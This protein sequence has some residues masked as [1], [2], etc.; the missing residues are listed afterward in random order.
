LEHA[1]HRLTLGGRVRVRAE[2]AELAGRDPTQRAAYDAVI[3][4]G[5][6]PPAVAAECGAPFLRVGG[7]LLTSEP[8]DERPW[9]EAPLGQLGLAAVGR[10]SGVMVLEQ[11]LACPDR[12]PRRSPAK[13]PLF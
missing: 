7:R 12:F 8:P 6:G 1:V 13:R 10:R 4:R 9:P 5:F 11:R 2:R 3:A